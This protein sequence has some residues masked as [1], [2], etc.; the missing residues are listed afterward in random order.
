MN[1]R[2]GRAKFKSFRIIFDSVFSS[3]IVK[4][5]LVG[6]LLPEK[7]SVIQW[8]TQDGNITTNFKIKIDFTL[9]TL[10][11]TNAVTWKYNVDES[12]KGGKYFILGRDMLTKLGLNLKFSEHVIKADDGP[13]KGST[14]PMVDLG[15]Y[16]FK[17]LNIGKL[18]LN[19]SLQTLMSKNYM[20]QNMCLMLKNNHL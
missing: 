13:F 6:K 19:N 3:T 9:P 17:I 11:A 2:K 8:K 15:A 7:D 4:R 14:A 12:T 10:S 1:S 20:S 16:I 18:N 5:R